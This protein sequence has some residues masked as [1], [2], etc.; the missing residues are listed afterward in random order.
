VPLSTSG[1]RIVDINGATVRLACV[2]WYGA[3]MER[4]VVDGLDKQPMDL[5]SE[6][7]AN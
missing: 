5:M 2:N 1:S 4:F 7:I 6:E 3:H